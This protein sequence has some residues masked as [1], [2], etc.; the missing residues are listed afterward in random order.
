MNKTAILLAVLIAGPASANV[1]KCAGPDGKTV[2]QESPCNAAAGAKETTTEWTAQREKEAREEKIRQ[3]QRAKE[4]EEAKKLKALGDP[5]SG[6][7]DCTNLYAYARNVRGQSWMMATAIA[8]E[9]EKKGD[10]IRGLADD[11]K[12]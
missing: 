11:P 3:A 9:A 6:P 12:K 8:T 4:R 2:Y 1:Y 10:C 7:V 5:S